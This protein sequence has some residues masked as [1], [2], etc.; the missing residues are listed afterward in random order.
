MHVI[1]RIDLSPTVLGRPLIDV[2]VWTVHDDPVVVDVLVV[3]D[4]IKHVIAKVC[5]LA[6]IR[7][8]LFRLLNKTKICSKRI[9]VFEERLKLLKLLLILYDEVAP[10]ATKEKIRMIRACAILQGKLC[11]LHGRLICER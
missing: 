6:Y 2:V 10:I 11:L 3:L 5:H 1:D 7:R 8:N 9:A 4:M